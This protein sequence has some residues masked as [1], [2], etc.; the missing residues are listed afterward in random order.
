MPLG[1]RELLLIVVLPALAALAILLVVSV[2]NTWD[3]MLW[4]AQ[5]RQKARNAKS[6][7]DS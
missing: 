5:D 6:T 1:P 3:L 4:I 2:R 7:M